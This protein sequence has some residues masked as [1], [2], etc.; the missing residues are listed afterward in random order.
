VFIFPSQKQS[1]IFL[2]SSSIHETH[3]ERGKKGVEMGRKIGYARVS[4]NE[5]NLDLQLKELKDV[6]CEEVFSDKTQ[7]GKSQ[8]PGLATC[9]ESL[10]TGDTLVVWRLDRLGRTMPHLV[11]LVTS[12]QE[13]GIGFKSLRDGVI[14]TTTASGELVFHIFAAL[15]QFERALIRE[16]TQAGLSAARARGRKGGRKPISSQDPRVRTA[17]KMHDTK[18]LSIKEIC[19]TLNISKAT[20]YRYLALANGS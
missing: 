14:D 20:L 5:Q 7:G 19:T 8:R 10:K 9:L 12:L 1:L 16:R 15:A 6:G 13:H 4:T 17:K 11:S 3:L 2:T 18:E